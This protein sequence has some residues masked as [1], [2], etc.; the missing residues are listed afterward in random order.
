MIIN[1]DSAVELK[2]IESD[3]VHA[4][5]TDPPHALGGEHIHCEVTEDA[6]GNPQV[7]VTFT[8]A[9]TGFMGANWDKGIGA[10]EVWKEVYRVLKPGGHVF[11]MS[12]E[13]TGGVAGFYLLLKAAGF[14]VDETQLMNWVS[15]T[16]MPKSVDITK[17]YDKR[18]FCKWLNLVGR[19]FVKCPNHKEPVVDGKRQR[20]VE[21]ER[22]FTEGCLTHHDK[23]R[24]ESAAVNGACFASPDDRNGDM[25]AGPG[26]W[27]Q[28]GGTTEVD[29]AD[30]LLSRLLASHWP[31]SAQEQRAHW[32]SVI[33]E[34]P[35][36]W[37]CSSPPGV[38]A[39]V[40]DYQPPE[41]N[42]AWNL[43]Q[44]EGEDTDHVGGTFTASG[45]RTLSITAPSTPISVEWDGWNGGVAPLKALAYPI[46][47]AQKPFS[48]TF[49]DCAVEHEV[50]PLNT[51]AAKI[52]FANADDAFDVNVLEECSGLEQHKRSNYTP[53]KKQGGREP[54][55][56]LSYGQLLGELQKHADLSTWCRQLGLP[57]EAA[58]LLEAGMIYAPKPGTKEKTCNGQVDALHPTVKPTALCAYLMV[59]CT[60]E[61]QTVLDPFC[62]SG[63][64]GIAAK[65]LNREF[66][67]IELDPEYAHT[68]E[69]RIQCT[70]VTADEYEE[71]EAFDMGD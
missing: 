48:G 69:M 31:T 56:I 25:G 35:E 19:K 46:L 65:L 33:D 11:V 42:G 53:Q 9:A 18:V 67:G 28:K 37:D 13:R 34:V 60:R 3:S 54:S 23:R 55:N 58:E 50:G 1:G 15:L 41:M 57:P 47:H 43:R 59:L 4:V 49:L 39:T 6:A 38:R 8:Q 29:A 20:C 68:A 44:A 71:Q 7:L 12:S 30:D 63:S 62:G 24:A 45:D 32:E 66:I 70:E 10:F 16:G 51:D 26:S 27:A 61:G 17:T 40:G 22:I 2:S 5:I 14:I 64:T 52:P 21:C 36:D